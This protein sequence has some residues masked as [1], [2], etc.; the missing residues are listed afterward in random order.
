MNNHQKEVYKMNNRLKDDKVLKILSLEDSIPDYEIIQ[1]HLVN[2]GYKMN[3][4]RVDSE[5]QYEKLIRNQNYDVIL[6]DF[7]L[8]GFDAFG[9]LLLHQEICP[10]IPFIC[11]SGSI[12]EETAIELL[13]KG[14]AD[15]VLKDRLER[16]PFAIKRALEE[17]REKEARQI[18]EENFIISETRYRRLFETA[19]D[20]ILIVDATSGYIVDVNPFLIKLLGYSRK[21]FLEKAIWEIGVFKDIVHNYDKFLELQQ[22]EYVRYE[23]LPLESSDGRKINV[24]F[25][26]N[27]Y[28]VDQL[29][30]I[31]CN[32]RDITIRKL[33]EI[34]LQES[35]ERLKI[36]L[37]HNPIAIWDWNIKTDTWLATQRYFT[38]LGYPPENGNLDRNVW[39]NR[40]HPDERETVNQKIAAV[41]NHTDDNYFYDVRMLHADGSY[42]WQTVIGNVIER[43]ENGLASRML[44]VRMDITDRKKAEIELKRKIDDLERFHK[45]TIGREIS[46]IELKKEVNELLKKSGQDE[47]YRIVG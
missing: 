5:T 41:L 11:V 45:L 1:E 3:L 9:A 14:A 38:M 7:K 34:A 2:S 43:D 18:A 23:N 36:I 44:G 35:N 6:A 28:L 42:R 22:N 19:K 4:I 39:I 20:G 26:S 32:I 46:M 10:K 27:V 13:K 8:P 40:I 17:V 25:V 31:Q 15:Y 21:E 24:E 37:D 30:V 47:K 12:G 29:K 33:A 16:L